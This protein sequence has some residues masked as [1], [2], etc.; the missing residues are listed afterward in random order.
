MILAQD[1]G[2]P[3]VNGYSG[4][5]PPGNHHNPIERCISAQERLES[6][7]KFKGTTSEHEIAQIMKQIV[8]IPTISCG[9]AK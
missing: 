6:Y 7:A 3:T 4:K 2:I 8:I 9:L 5:F 1:I